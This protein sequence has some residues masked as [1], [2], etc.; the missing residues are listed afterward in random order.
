MKRFAKYFSI[1]TGFLI[2]FFVFFC[3]WFNYAGTSYTLISFF[4]TV[5][6]YE[7]VMGFAGGVTNL[8]LDAI[9]ADPLLY[10]IAPAY[11]FLFF[12]FVAAIF[13]LLRSFLLLSTRFGKVVH[14]LTLSAYWVGFIYLAAALVF[15]S[16]SPCIA[17]V[18]SV[19]ML[20]FDFL[21]SLYS[22]QRA[23]LVRRAVALKLAEERARAEKR[24]RMHFPG[25]Y[26]KEFYQVV[27]ANFRSNFTSYSL[28]IL[29]AS[30]SSALLYT[31]FGMYS[32]ITSI[33]TK[34][35]FL[36]GD[37]ILSIMKDFLPMLLFISLMLFVLILSNYIRTRMKNYGLFVS[38]GIRKKTLCFIIAQEYLFCILFS[39]AL[40]LFLGNIILALVRSMFHFTAVFSASTTVNYSAVFIASMSVYLILVGLATLVN[41]HLFEGIDISA[42]MVS[43]VKSEPFPKHLL[44]P[45][46]LYGL[47]LIIRT[48]GRFFCGG[49]GE[50]TSLL[51]WLLT[52][53]FLLL[54]FGGSK[55]IQRYLKNETRLLPSLLKIL[56]LRYRFRTNIKYLIL[57]LIIQL[58]AF[59]AFLPRLT[60]CLIAE[61]EKLLFP[62]DFV[63]MTHESDSAFF[64]QLQDSFEIECQQIPMVR[65]NSMLNEPYS[66]KQFFNPSTSGMVQ[67]PGQHIGISESSYQQ[68][69]TAAGIQD[70][71]TPQLKDDEIHIVF[72]QDS[73]WQ[74]HP[75]DWSQ[76]SIRPRLSA[77]MYG[78]YNYGNMDEEIPLYHV[79]SQEAKILTGMFQGGS[80][81]NIVVFSDD[82]FKQ[83][84][85][86][87]SSNLTQEPTP[88]ELRLIQSNAK[89]FTEVKNRLDKFSE[90]HI[91]DTYLNPLIRPYYDR[92]SAL[93]DATTERFLKETSYTA[94]LLLLLLGSLFTFYLKFSLELDSLADADTFFQYL[95]MRKKDRLKKVQLEM[96][97]HGIGSWAA[98]LIIAL[99]FILFIPVSRHFSSA[100]CIR[101][102]LVLSLLT[103]IYLLLYQAGLFFLKR[104]F[105]HNIIHNR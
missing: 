61:P 101:Y 43:S 40:G 89:D 76:N 47:W 21:L 54:F 94:L 17:L 18:I 41:Y 1:L 3:N 2:F 12:P 9:S 48:F 82:Y 87:V 6:D 23:E 36:L 63:C 46:M 24:K 45:C 84:Y 99:P 35:S 96:N 52:G 32:F 86:A 49:W 30:V 70:T 79:K 78:P 13:L 53:L 97:L 104:H 33:H 73:S 98:A 26:T 50:E 90:E 102:F 44:Y 11:F 100:Q 69:K 66:W 105:I 64:E 28:F 75:L 27:F 60:G 59:A 16:Y 65:I 39:G 42:S 88:T 62:Y 71:W 10:N 85:T 68:L 77:G 37:R 56:P 38:L 22:E 72:Q 103:G 20:L 74:S 92:A 31:L 91:P 29:A 8:S 5:S 81:E 51:I 58:F 80:Q 67:P 7:N 83:L 55:L 34:G 15:L 25:K 57:L 19:I 14:F 93:A 95:G 4:S